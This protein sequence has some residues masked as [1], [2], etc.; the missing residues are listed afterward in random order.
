MILLKHIVII[1]PF[2]NIMEILVDSFKYGLAP[3]IIVLFYLI[4]TRILDHRREVKKIEAQ[5]IEA[6]KTVKINSELINSFNELAS[7]LKFVTKDVVELDANKADAA[8]RSSFRSMNFGLTRFATFTIINNNVQENKG[9]IVDN[10]K[11]TVEAEYLNVYNELVLY[12]DDNVR[13]SE[14]LDPLWKDEINKIMIDVIFNE[15]LTKEQ[16]IYNIH[17]RL[18][19]D[20]TNYS[21]VVHNKFIKN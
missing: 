17:N 6:K 9:A 1:K 18:G 20:I 3:A 15:R 21:N 11:A 5:A 19:I 16:K 2:F 10:I 14:Y 12:K 7:Y 4:V 8:I 13:I